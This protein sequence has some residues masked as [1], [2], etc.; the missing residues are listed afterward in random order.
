MG[1]LSSGVGMGPLEEGLEDRDYCKFLTIS[2][3]NDT[4]RGVIFPG[5]RLRAH[6]RLFIHPCCGKMM[7]L[8]LYF[9]EAKHAWRVA[10]FIDGEYLNAVLRSEF[11]SA[12]INF[13][14]LSNRLAG[15]ASILRTCYYT[16]PA[17]R[18]NPPTPE[19][20]ARYAGQRQ[21]FRAL[22]SFPRHTVRLGRLAYRGSDRDGNPIFDQ[23]QVDSLL[24]LDLVQLAAKQ[25]IQETVLV[26]GDSD[27]ITAVVAAK[28]E[29][30]LV[31]LFHGNSPHNDLW[32]EAD[33]RT[34]FSQA[35]IDSVRR[36]LS[37]GP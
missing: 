20:D 9:C 37:S 30:V 2:H 33:E 22:E 6:A 5:I 35:F 10:I 26:A 29:G 8:P 13:L 18:S 19:E 23:K 7:V 31:R 34:Q 17:Y 3:R 15:E 28:S 24:T 14:D 21:F 4:I 11:G 12:R 1:G 27:F 36:Q 25:A 32:R 16:A